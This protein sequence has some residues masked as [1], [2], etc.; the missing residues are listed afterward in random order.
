MLFHEAFCFYHRMPAGHRDTAVR[1]MQW[2]MLYCSATG[3]KT[4]ASKKGDLARASKK[5]HGINPYFIFY[6]K[7][8]VEKHVDIVNIVSN[9]PMIRKTMN[10][11]KNKRIRV[12][13]IKGEGEEEDSEN[14][15]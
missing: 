8:A 9:I 2:I 3:C 11:L 7:V 12:F 10:S 6:S 14:R 1:G 13:S 4:P 15:N 5:A